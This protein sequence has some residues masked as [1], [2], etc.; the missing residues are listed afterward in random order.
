MVNHLCDR[1]GAMAAPPGCR[2]VATRQKQANGGRMFHCKTSGF[3]PILGLLYAVLPLQ[4]LD[5]A[6]SAFKAGAMM[7]PF[8]G[9]PAA[10][11]RRSRGGEFT[12]YQ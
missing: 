11:V 8:A 7:N 5:D 10:S 12:L 3:R 1:A 9:I 2:G 6:V 4:T